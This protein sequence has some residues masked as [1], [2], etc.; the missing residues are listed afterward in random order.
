MTE[1]NTMVEPTGNQAPQGDGTVIVGA[2]I[3]GLT[4]GAEL[5]RA[6]KKVVVLEADDQVGGLCRSY[7]LDGITFDLGPHLFFYNQDFPPDHYMMSLLTDEVVIQNRFRFAI[8]GKGRHWKMPL[9]PLDILLCYP[10]RYKKQILLSVLGKGEPSPAA[11]ESLQC[12]MEQKTGNQYYQDIFGP[13]F[14]SKTGW[15]GGE[16]HNDWVVRV[17]RDINN[18]KKPFSGYDKVISLRHK[19]ETIF[20]PTYYYPSG[21]FV[22]FAQRLAEIICENGGDVVCNCGQLTLERRKDILTGVTSRHQSYSPENVIWTPSV[23]QLNSLLGVSCQPLPYLDTAIVLLTYKRSRPKK[24]P[25]VYTYH[26]DEGTSFYRLY[27]PDNI[28]IKDRLPDREGICAELLLTPSLGQLTDEELMD[29]VAAD[30]EK[31]SLFR[32]EDLCMHRLFRLRENLPFYGL[33]YETSMESGYRTIHGIENLFSI[34]RRGGFY[35]CLT[36]AAINQ[37]LQMAAHLLNNS[38]EE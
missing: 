36:P 29:R 14:F 35:F 8:V 24:R 17:D 37:G 23:N 5:A 32:Q 1:M 28:F 38:Q 27:Y 7:E 31:I 33:D 16:I 6:G 4:V 22:R 20:R 19:L 30:I 21:G 18:N 11:P 9:N 13:L 2:G 3:T 10:W 25:Y 15:P 34:G 12:A 26:I